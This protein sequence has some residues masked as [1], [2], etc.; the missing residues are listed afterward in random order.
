MTSS[1]LHDSLAALACLILALALEKA[2]PRHVYVLK[3]TLYEHSYPHKEN[4]VPSWSVPVYSLLGPLVLFVSYHLVR[5]WR[6]PRWEAMRLVVGLCLAYFLTGAITNCLK[7]PVGR[8]RPNFVR[9]CWPNGTMV[10]E[11][12]DQW[13]GYPVCDPSV[14]DGDLEEIRKSWPSGH[15]SLSAAGLGYASWFALGQFRSFSH[16]ASEGRQWGFLLALLPSF[17]AVAVAVTRVLDY[18]HFPSDALTGLAIGFLT[19]FWVYRLLYPPLT[20]PRCELSWDMLQ[21]AEAREERQQLSR[22]AERDPQW[23]T[24]RSEPQP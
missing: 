15:S 22:A 19:S 16:S 7:L 10:F 23:G 14:G 17:G 1:L 18:W 24:S 11:Q 5:P 2:K 8:P 13:G 6:L 12:E 9:V 4:T 21:A 20:H 3:E